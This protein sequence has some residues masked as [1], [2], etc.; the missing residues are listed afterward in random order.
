MNWPDVHEVRVATD[1]EWV[2]YWLDL[3]HSPRT[4]GEHRLAVA[5]QR[6]LEE[7]RQA[8]PRAVAQASRRLRRAA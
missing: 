4:M 7:L 3:L 8:S 5:L 1:P 2:L 6:R